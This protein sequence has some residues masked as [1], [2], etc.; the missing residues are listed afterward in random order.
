MSDASPDSKLVALTGASGFVGRHILARAAAAGLRLRVLARDPARL[1]DLPEAADVVRGGLEDA[2]ALAEL[3]RGSAAVVHCAGAVR[4]VTRAQFD[5]VNVAGTA[6]V[7]RAAAAAGA[8]RFLQISSLAAREPAL[9]AYAASKRAGEEAA[10]EALGDLPLTVFRPPAVYGPGDREMLTLFRLMARG[11]APVF[12]E[13]DARF[14]LLFVTDLA[15]A[16]VAW[17]T[18]DRPPVATFEPDDGRP[19]GHGWEDV[20]ETVASITGRPVRPLRLPTGVLALPAGIN[21]AAGRLTS[22]APMLTPG[23]LRELRHPD[24]VCRGTSIAD[25]LGWAPAHDLRAGL[26]A[27]P[28]WRD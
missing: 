12:G 20:C 22:F 28:G 15:D 2:T 14:S 26:L 24:W 7:A 8:A 6:A 4:G 13:P 16:V 11:Y 17:L 10:R 5:R 25:S 23:K 9:S 21:Y 3:V 19:G 18:A 27:T 1:P